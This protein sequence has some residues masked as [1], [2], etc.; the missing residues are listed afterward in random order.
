MANYEIFQVMIVIPR[1]WAES[2]QFQ[3]SPLDVATP[4]KSL[5][6][7]KFVASDFSHGKI[8]PGEIERVKAEQISSFI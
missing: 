5:I 6:V 7:A 1:K 3:I 8:S 2:G 4:A